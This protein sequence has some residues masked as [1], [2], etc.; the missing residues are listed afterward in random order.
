MWMKSNHSTETSEYSNLQLM[1]EFPFISFPFL[2]TFLLFLFMVFKTKFSSSPKLP[3]GPW[4]L[5][6]IGNIHQF[7]GTLP[8]HRLRDLATKH[9]PLMHLQLGQ[10]SIVVISS[11]EIAKEVMKTHDIIFASRPFNLAVSIISEKDIALAPYGDYWRQLRKICILELLSVK[12]V[13][14]FRPIREEETLNLI[15]SIFTHTGSLINLSEKLF[16]LTYSITAKATIGK[17]FHGQKEFISLIRQAAVVTG[18]FKLADLFPSVKVLPLINGLRHRLEKLH[19]NLDRAFTNIIDDHKVSKVT[20]QTGDGEAV[21][22]DLVD[23]LLKL[24]EKGNL[25]IPLTTSAIKSVLL[26]MFGGGIETSS[27]TLIWAMSELLKNSRIMEKAQA[28]VRHVS[29]KIGNILTEDDIHE[30]SYLKLVIKETLRVH[31]PVPLLIPRESRERCE[32][33]GYEIP[34]KTQILVN[35]WAIGRDPKNWS[36]PERFHPERF[37]DTS[38]DYKGTHFQF[39]PFGAG[40]RICPGISFA[41]ANVELALANLLYHFDWKLPNGE[42]QGDLD[43]TEAFGGAVS[44]KRDLC[45]TP[46][47]YHL[48]AGE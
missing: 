36:D 4:K 20:T 40:R 39:T 23:V 38:I 32:I 46:I 5:P 1:M 29:C 47:A 3:P 27:T 31:P 41:V 2:F 19:Q 18:G 7:V 10:L 43:M 8:H 15:K 6:L 13:Q 45:V 22:E 33:N 35:V 14:S 17:K 34:A 24:Q 16:S 21:H 44:K 42:K 11:A 9:G 37:L 30:L 25:E 26:D 28:E 12:R 48:L